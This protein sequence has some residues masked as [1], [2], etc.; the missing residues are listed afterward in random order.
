MS[1]N[2]TFCAS[3]IG[4]AAALALA[5]LA[6]APT[7]QA[8]ATGM[9][10]TKDADTGK[11]RAATAEEAATLDA[12]SAKAKS[13]SSAKRGLR[14]GKLNPQAIHHTDGTVEQELD[15]S[16]LTYSVMTRKADGSM[17]LTCVDGEK[18]AN[19]L[20]KGKRSAKSAAA[21]S[22]AHKEQSYDK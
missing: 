15:E 11:L 8:Q 21:H 14:T 22:H 5:A 10:V 12:S 13:A 9:R 17:E 1:I 18:A 16:S 20:V 4:L 6:A 19:E 2:R 7:A 3:R